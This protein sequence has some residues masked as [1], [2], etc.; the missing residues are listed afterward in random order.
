MAV[1]NSREVTEYEL[2]PLEFHIRKEEAFQRHVDGNYQV[3]KWNGTKVSRPD[4]VYAFKHDLELLQKARHR[5][6]VQF[7]GAV[8]QDSP[9]PFKSNLH[10]FE[11]CSCFLLDLHHGDLG[12]YVQVKERLSP[13]KVLRF[14][15]DIARD[16][17]YLH[18]TK[19]DPII[20][21][22]LKPKNILLDSGGLLKVVGFGLVRLLKHSSDKANLAYP[23]ALPEFLSPYTAPG[24]YKNE[25]FDRS[26]GAIS[27]RL[28]LHEMTEGMPPFHPSPPEEAARM[29]F[30]EG[31][32]PPFKMKSKSYPPE[33]KELIEECWN[34]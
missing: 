13:A 11:Y 18:Q 17:N 25:T 30:F 3:A 31:L 24:V 2:N 16:M 8:T 14:A 19:P 10:N 34:P 6:V 27:C 33:L 22:D 1:T 5:N 21:C 26:V 9:V 23:E 7:I 4:C 12:R 32:R 20:H 28:I 15:L 29:I